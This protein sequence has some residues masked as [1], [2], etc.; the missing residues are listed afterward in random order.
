MLIIVQLITCMLYFLDIKHF[1]EN[2]SKHLPFL[3]TFMVV[4]KDGTMFRF[5]ATKA[6]FL[7]SPFT[8]LRRGAIYILTHPYP[9][10]IP[11]QYRI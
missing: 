4:S 5:S 9:F 2:L 3:Q 11:N 6:F 7:L 1:D 10:L 8:K